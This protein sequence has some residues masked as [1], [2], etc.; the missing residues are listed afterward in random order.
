MHRCGTIYTYIYLRQ[1]F[2]FIFRCMCRSVIYFLLPFLNTHPHSKV[3]GANMWPTWVMSAPDGPMLAQ[4]TLLSGHF[5]FNCLTN[6]HILS[7]SPFLFYLWST[8]W[9]PL[10]VAKVSLRFR[11]H[12][13]ETTLQL[14]K[15]IA[16]CHFS[17]PCSDVSSISHISSFCAP[18]RP[19]CRCWVEVCRWSSLQ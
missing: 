15:Q 2:P 5:I 16:F 10:W 17:Q 19:V 13:L 12:K 7:P 11:H 18:S 14:T 8:R 1:K 3:H 4:W 9:G 6:K